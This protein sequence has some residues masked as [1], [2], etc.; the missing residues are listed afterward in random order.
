[1]T[2]LSQGH[3]SARAPAAACTARRDVAVSI[4]PGVLLPAVR[5][6]KSDSLTTSNRLSYTRLPLLNLEA[7]S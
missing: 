3:A 6:S 2:I 4:L 5:I 1:M 7:T